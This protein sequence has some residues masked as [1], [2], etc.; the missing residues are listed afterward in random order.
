MK[1][2]FFFLIERERMVRTMKREMKREYHLLWL[3][4]GLCADYLI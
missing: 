2:L 1:T 4:K 3:V